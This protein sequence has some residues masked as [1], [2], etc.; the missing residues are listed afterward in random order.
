MKVKVHAASFCSFKEIDPDGHM[1]LPKNAVLN[2]VCKKLRIPFPIRKLM[3]PSVNHQIVPLKTKLEE[4]DVI[5][6]FS[7]L[8]GG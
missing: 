8:G 3:L 6:F 5:S 1:T 7:G 2:D 4:G